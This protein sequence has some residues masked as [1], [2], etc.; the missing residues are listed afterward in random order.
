LKR[1]A[2]EKR[3]LQREEAMNRLILALA[4]GVI[5]PAAL[6]TAS[7]ALAQSYP[8]RPI[9]LVAP[10]PPGASVDGLARITRDVLSEIL[11]QTI[12]IENRTGA[13]GTQ[14]ANSVATAAPDGYTLLVTVNAPITMNSFMQKSY[15]FDPKTA[16]T[17]ITLAAETSLLLAVHPSVPASNV[18][19]L[20]AY[21]KTGA[22]KLSYGSAGVGS[23]HHITGELLKQKTGIDMN[24]VPYRGGGPAIQDLVAGHIQISFGTP[25]SVLPQSSAGRI[26]VIATSE[27]K[28]FPDLPDVPTIAETVPGYEASVSFG[29]FAAAGTPTHIIKK[30]NA[31]VQKI[32]SDPEFQKTYLERFALQ[33]VPGALDAFAEY[34]RKDSAKWREVIHA[35]HVKIE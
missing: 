5:V 23:G 4:R 18:A 15:P 33:P 11:G 34:L 14:G 29:L 16:F 10:F 31:D 7:A 25:P 27:E 26:R 17:P 9:T 1:Q 13:G 21:A 32:V 8:A 2:R 22:V 12:V 35:A 24:H 30:V 20:V 6:L 19:E 3:R 28:R